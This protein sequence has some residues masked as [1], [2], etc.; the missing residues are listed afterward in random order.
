MLTDFDIQRTAK[1]V[2]DL[3]LADDR[4]L[5]RMQKIAP[6]TT[7]RRLK[8]K[9]AAELLG[10]SVRMLR[11]AAPYIGGIKNGESNNNPYYFDEEGLKERYNEYLQNKK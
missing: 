10:I 5:A 11:N 2:V 6:K 3:L 4:F 8:A 9:D 1:A 7:S